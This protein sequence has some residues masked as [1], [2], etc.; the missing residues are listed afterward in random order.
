MATVE[1]SAGVASNPS[2]AIGTASS[3]LLSGNLLCVGPQWWIVGSYRDDFWDLHGRLFTR[4]EFGGSP[5]ALSGRDVR[6][7]SSRT[8]IGAFGSLVVMGNML[9]SDSG[10]LGRLVENP[11]VWHLYATRT[12]LRDL[13]IEANPAG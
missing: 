13:L 4:L 5:L 9:Y 10:I 8:P 7:D 2:I 3:F 6:P 12:R 1:L 11:F